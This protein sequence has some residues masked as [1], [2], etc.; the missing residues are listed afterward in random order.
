MQADGTRAPPLAVAFV[1]GGA[2]HARRRAREPGGGA[3]ATAVSGRRGQRPRRARLDGRLAAAAGAADRVSR[4]HF[5][6]FPQLRWSFSH[7]RELFPT[8]DIAR[9]TRPVS[10]LPRA[11]RADLDAVTFVPLGGG[12][13]LTWAQS[14]A[15]NYTDGI[16]VLHRGRIVYE[17]YFG[18]LRPDGRHIAHSVTKTFFG[19]IAAALVAEGKL[20]PVAPV[21]RYVPELR[22][23][24]FGDA[25]VR[26]VM[27]MTTAL[28]YSEAYADPKAEVWDFARAGGYAETR[29]LPRPALVVRVPGDGEE[30]RRA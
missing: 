1:G 6:R 3:V 21:T 15:A 27:D 9:G 7:W 2:A 4:R 14:L 8:A 12:T 17:R 18:A 29:R 22:D 20:D 30:E 23:S 16:V 19:T 5:Y 26:Q 28:A 11:A 24:A 25:T 10:A 13:T